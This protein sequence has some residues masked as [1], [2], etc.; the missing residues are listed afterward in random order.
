MSLVDRSSCSVYA[1]MHAV[2]TLCDGVN[3]HSDHL[4][5]VDGLEDVFF[6][7]GTEGREGEGKRS[8]LFYA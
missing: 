2:F 7:D 6:D 3:V 1:N 4:M 5:S 8:W